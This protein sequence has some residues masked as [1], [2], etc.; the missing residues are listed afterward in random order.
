M[1]PFPS[2]HFLLRQKLQRH[3][4]SMLTQFIDIC[5]TKLTD[6]RPFGQ[7]PKARKGRPKNFQLLSE[8][9]NQFKEITHR[10]RYKKNAFSRA[11]RVYPLV[12]MATHIWLYYFLKC[13][14]EIGR[15]MVGTEEGI[16]FHK[17]VR[18]L[19]RS[20]YT[21]SSTRRIDPPMIHGFVRDRG[22]FSLC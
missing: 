14:S 13:S 2:E 11:I 9:R 16:P 18:R 6:T 21:P 15:Y 8:P 5:S 3:P 12:I 20:R 22:K 4:N 7:E 1:A 10:S 17:A 19:R